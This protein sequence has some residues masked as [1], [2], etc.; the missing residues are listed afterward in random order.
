MHFSKFYTIS[1][2]LSNREV[3]NL[4]EQFWFSASLNVGR[5]SAT[6][7]WPSL[8]GVSLEANEPNHPV[9]NYLPLFH[10]GQIYC[11]IFIHVT[12]VNS[13]SSLISSDSKNVQQQN[14]FVL[15][16]I[17]TEIVSLSFGR[18][19]QVWSINDKKMKFNQLIK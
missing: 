14:S 18:C 16:V 3:M 1:I 7:W 9:L 4:D 6:F 5:S 19:N 11:Q 8:Q 12:D 10:R 2:N 17:Y 13:D 15:I